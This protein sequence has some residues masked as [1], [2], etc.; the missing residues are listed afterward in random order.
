M[1]CLPNPGPPNQP[2]KKYK[3]GFSHIG[4]SDFLL[5]IIPSLAWMF[6][7]PVASTPSANESA[8]PFVDVAGTVCQSPMIAMLIQVVNTRR[9]STVSKKAFAAV[10]AA[11]VTGYLMLWVL[12]FTSPITPMLLVMMVVLPSAYLICMELFLENYPPIIPAV[13]FSMIH[14]GTTATNCP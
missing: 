8:L 3:L 7:P 13:F 4:A 10:A 6:L 14:I 5:P 12:Y 2:S 1:K 9:Q 11:C